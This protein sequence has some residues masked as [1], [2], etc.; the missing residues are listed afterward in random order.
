M[1]EGL[2]NNTLS[3]GILRINKMNRQD[4]YVRSEGGDAN[5]VFVPG[6]KNQNRALDGDIVIVRA[7]V[8]ADLD[9]GF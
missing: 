5:D 3:E 4:G 1:A 9:R 6:V 2:Q 8:D 7:L